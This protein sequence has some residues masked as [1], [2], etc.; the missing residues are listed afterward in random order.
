MKVNIS[1][2]AVVNQNGRIAS[3]GIIIQSEKSRTELA[4]VES[5]PEDGMPQ[6]DADINAIGAAINLVLS[7]IGFSDDVVTT[8]YSDSKKAIKYYNDN[9]E[10]FEKMIGFHGVSF[11][12]VDTDCNSH[13]R[14]RK[15]WDNK[16]CEK[17][18]KDIR[19]HY[20]LER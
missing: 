6:T 1:V 2:D 10:H 13:A 16:K 15:Q 12:Y 9:L 3:H 7:L 18:A 11:V 5:T 4:Y 14:S 19:V 20:M 17:L 8:V